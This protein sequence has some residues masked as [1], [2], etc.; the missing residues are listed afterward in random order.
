MNS[1]TFEVVVGTNDAGEDIKETV[2]IEASNF[3]EARH[4]LEEF[5]QLRQQS[6]APN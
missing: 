3:S 2:A 5:V 1:Y 6:A 4:K